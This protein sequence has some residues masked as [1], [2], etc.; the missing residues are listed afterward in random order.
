M[1]GWK[2]SEDHTREDRVCILAEYLEQ[3]VK[4]TDDLCTKAQVMDDLGVTSKELGRIRVWASKNAPERL[5]DATG[6]TYRICQTNGQLEDRLMHGIY[7]LQGTTNDYLRFIEAF[8]NRFGKISE[9]AEAMKSGLILQMWGLKKLMD[10][11]HEMNYQFPD[12][13]EVDDDE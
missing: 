3:W 13:S 12:E 6:G 2:I 8:E 1:N 4:E 11:L 5:I 10:D 7:T 9:F